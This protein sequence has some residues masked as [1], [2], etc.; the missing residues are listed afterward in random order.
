VQDLAVGGLLPT[1]TK[2][3]FNLQNAT[4]TPLGA[5]LEFTLNTLLNDVPRL[6]SLLFGE[7]HATYIISYPQEQEALLKTT[8]QAAANNSNSALQFHVLG[9]VTADEQLTL[10]GLVETPIIG[11]T[12]SFQQTWEGCF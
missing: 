8:L 6:D 4:A 11:F 2:S 12:H 5:K 7:T 3:C 9:D 1:L 10:V